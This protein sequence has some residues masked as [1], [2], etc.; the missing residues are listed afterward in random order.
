MKL[1]GSPITTIF[2]H[3]RKREFCGSEHNW[4][5]FSSDEGKFCNLFKRGI[6]SV[7]PHNPG[8]EDGLR[9]PECLGVFKEKVK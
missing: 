3:G 5:R 8:Y 6:Y 7:F 4:C 9:C 1:I 2:A